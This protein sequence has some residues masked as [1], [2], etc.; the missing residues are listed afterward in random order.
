MHNVRERGAGDPVLVFSHGYGSDLRAW[1]TVASAFE[2]RHRTVLFDH[3]GFGGSD[4]RAYDARRHATLD[5]YARDLIDLL[6]ELALPPVRFI[7]HSVGGMIGLLASIE[8]PE[9]FERL[10]LV[11]SSPSFI[12]HRPGY[13]GGFSREEIESLLDLMRRDRLAWSQTLAPIAIGNQGSHA[14]QQAFEDSL[15]ALDPAITDRFAAL[16]FGIDVRDSLPRVQVPV[17][18]VQ[19]LRDRIVP[20]EVGRW[21]HAR[22]PSSRLCELDASGHCPHL[23]H[24]ALLI[25]VLRPFLDD[26]AGD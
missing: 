23:T 5:G 17:L 22:M 14:Q 12:D 6:D 16:A 3:V 9:R 10:V 18:I 13:V 11:G 2:G 25:E 20:V 19:C 8:A 26:D 15:R 21:M 4:L 1:Q 24:P 7:G